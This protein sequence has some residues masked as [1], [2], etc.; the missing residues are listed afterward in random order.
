MNILIKTLWLGIS[1]S[2]SAALFAAGDHDHDDHDDEHQHEER[3][4]VVMSADIAVASGL[5]TAVAGEGVLRERIKLYGNIVA[6]PLRVSH[7]QA[8]YPGLIRSVKP[9]IGSRVKAGEILAMVESNESLRE[10]PLHAPIDGVVIERHANPG[11]FTADRV[12]F[13]LLD[14]SVLELHLQAFPADAHKIKTGQTI[15]ISANSLQ[16]HTASTKTEYITPRYGDTPT[17]EVHAPV[18]NSA[19]MWVPNQAVEGWVDVAQTPVA[20]RVDNRALQQVEKRVGV[21]VQDSHQT[22]GYE[23]HPLQLGRSDG[24]FTEVIEGLHAGDR[25]V[26]ENAYLLKADLEKSGAAHDH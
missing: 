24:E 5:T 22:Q 1:L 11:E 12:L 26:V 10:Y 9:T 17:L 8:R 15:T 23:F 4:N 13:T 3:T 16:T 25:Y 6:D 2:M 20:L 7:I 19:G 18:D 14:E 21:F